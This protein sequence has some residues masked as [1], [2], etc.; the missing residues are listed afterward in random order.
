MTS[1]WYSAFLSPH[2]FCRTKQY[3]FLWTVTNVSA[4]SAL[5]QAKIYMDPSNNRVT[6]K[7]PM[8]MPPLAMCANLERPSP[9]FGSN[10]AWC[11]AHLS[12]FW[13]G[14]GSSTVHRMMGFHVIRHWAGGANSAMNL[15]RVQS[16]VHVGRP[17]CEGVKESWWEDVSS[18]FLFHKFIHVNWGRNWCELDNTE[19]LKENITFPHL[20]RRLKWRV[21]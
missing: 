19:W 14:V 5:H 10:T 16:G 6:H 1:T 3:V 4:S 18:E 8:T 2:E 21:W 12:A 7:T 11:S 15:F 9:L 20:M 17:R 13:L